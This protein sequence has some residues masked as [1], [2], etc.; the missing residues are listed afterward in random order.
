MMVAMLKFYLLLL[1]VFQVHALVAAEMK[2][3]VLMLD[4]N[5]A[6]EVNLRRF[7][8]MTA[9]FDPSP[10]GYTPSREGLDALR[11]SGSAQF[12]KQSFQTLLNVL[13][14]KKVIV[15]DMRQ[16]SH[17][18]VNEM[19]V[20]W[21]AENNWANV[22]RS[23]AYIEMDEKH[24]L[25]QLLEEGTAKVCQKMSEEA[26]MDCNLSFKVATV[27]T[28]QQLCYDAGVAYHR[29]PV[30]DHSP[31]DNV[32]IDHFIAIVKGQP[33]DAWVHIHCAGGSGRTTALLCFYDMMHNAK[34]VSLKDILYRQWLLGGKN[35]ISSASDRWPQQ[36][37]ARKKILALFY[38]YCRE[39]APQFTLSW[40]DWLHSKNV[41]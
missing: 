8:T 17:G 26:R 36:F 19:P 18:F 11:A 3:P 20:S 39:E 12:S 10:D 37:A 6:I 1:M 40:S 24:R 14:L 4:Q 5:Q 28:E 32:Q 9:P 41:Q 23:L 7:R 15:V 27:A 16:E 29:L 31:P 35:F 22:G 34:H 25:H 33:R 2:E 13:P 21:Y 30:T 38:E